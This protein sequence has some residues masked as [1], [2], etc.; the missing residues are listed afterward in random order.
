MLAAWPGLAVEAGVLAARR[1]EALGVAAAAALTLGA[2]EAGRA[3]RLAAGRAR[4]ERGNFELP[5]CSLSCGAVR[6]IFVPLK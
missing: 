5:A 6:F 4:R 3:R 2:A 1:R